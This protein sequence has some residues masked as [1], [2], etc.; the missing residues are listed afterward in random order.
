MSEETDRIDR[1]GRND[2]IRDLL[3]LMV[4]IVLTTEA[5]Q[6]VWVESVWHTPKA[7]ADHVDALAKQRSTKRCT[8][9][10]EIVSKAV[11]W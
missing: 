3:P 1:I 6:D 11:R 4:W 8:L 10:Y 9:T 7:A 5:S 2:F